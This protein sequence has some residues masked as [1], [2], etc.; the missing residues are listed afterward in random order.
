M[1]EYIQAKNLS[2]VKLKSLSLAAEGLL[3][4]IEDK[5]KDFEF[6]KLKLV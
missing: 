1:K 4:I 5:L 6:R 2:V 3:E